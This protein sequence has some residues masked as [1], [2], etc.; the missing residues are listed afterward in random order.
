LEIVRAGQSD[1]RTIR[2][3]K[4]TVLRAVL[5]SVGQSV[6]GSAVLAGERPVPLDLPLE[7]SARYV[8][9]PTFSGG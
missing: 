8:V 6:E 9:I 5:R 7:K 3:P 2:V 1:V 4:G